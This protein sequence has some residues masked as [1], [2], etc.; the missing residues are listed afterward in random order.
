[1]G[2]K[3]DFAKVFGGGKTN[4]DFKVKNKNENI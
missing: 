1:M 2:K 4:Y 3:N